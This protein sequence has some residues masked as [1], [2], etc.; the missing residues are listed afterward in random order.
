MKP[1]LPFLL[2]LLLTPLFAQEVTIHDFVKTVDNNRE[3]LIYYYENNWKV[4]REIALERGFIESYELMI[5]EADSLADFD[6]ILITK[7][8][9]E[10][11]YDKGEERFQTIIRDVIGDGTPKL[12]NNLKPSEFRRSVFHKISHTF[13]SS[14]KQ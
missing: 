12:L 3:E 2:T 11:A 5:T 7:Y 13:F 6:V 1:V 9:D 4:F 10:E 8:E 14:S